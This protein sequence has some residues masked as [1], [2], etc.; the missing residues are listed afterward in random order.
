[1]LCG[2]GSVAAD[3][4]PAGRAVRTA[5]GDRALRGPPRCAQWTWRGRR[6][7]S[8]W[9]R[10]LPGRRGPA[11][12]SMPGWGQVDD[13]RVADAG[14]VHRSPRRRTG[15]G[16]RSRTRG[17]RTS[18][19]PTS[20]PTWVGRRR[21]D[22][23]TQSTSWC[24][25]GS[26]AERRDQHRARATTLSRSSTRSVR[27]PA[28]SG[29]GRRH[30]RGPDSPRVAPTSGCTRSTR[31]TGWCG[32]AGSASRRSPNG[33]TTFGGAGCCRGR[34]RPRRISRPS[35]RRR[36]RSWSTP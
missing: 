23:P 34:H 1:M 33:V 18:A 4:T 30:P 9:R 24:H 15:P 27:T 11:H 26:G 25:S 10:A 31:S 19:A 29:D 20:A 13:L 21:S 16:T 7:T 36:R 3:A 28:G 17:G 35:R 22:P 14:R 32:R 12:G 2:T 5:V 8:A 6:R